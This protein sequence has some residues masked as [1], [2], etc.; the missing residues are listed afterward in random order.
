MHVPDLYA[1][2]RE[3]KPVQD[4]C[5]YHMIDSYVQAK[6]YMTLCLQDHS[7]ATYQRGYSQV[8][9]L[10]RLIRQHQ[11]ATLRAF[12]NRYEVYHSRSTLHLPG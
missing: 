4:F 10:L 5:A 9:F 1:C 11:H 2:A 12:H 7:L 3:V 6:S 8:C